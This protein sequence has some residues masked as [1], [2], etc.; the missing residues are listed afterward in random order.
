MPGHDFYFGRKRAR[1]CRRELRLEPDAPLACVLT[2]VEDCGVHVVAGQLRDGV[3]G[4]YQGRGTFHLVFVD[5]ASTWPA[6]RR[7]TL[8][9][10]LGH[11]RMRHGDPPVDTEQT[12]K[13][14]A[15][16]GNEVRA[17]AFAGELLV[18]EDA[19]KARVTKEPGL[20]E[21][22]LLADEYGVSPIAM[23]VRL[24][25][26]GCVGARREQRLKEEIEDGDHLT[27]RDHLGLTGPADRV[28]QLDDL[29]YVSA[30]LRGSALDDVLRGRTDVR[31]AA[32][33]SGVDE[34]ALRAAVELLAAPGRADE[35]AA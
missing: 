34:D 27:L 32:E 8:A 9:H 31:T 14:T 18:P 3:A 10:E 22:V 4:A 16:D 28:A 1:E 5:T 13:D 35:Q 15:Y 11:A 19:L 26:A 33:V 6:R 25:I 20:E 21:V 23:V 17:N 24:C 29:P 7:F 30:P 12:L 2:T